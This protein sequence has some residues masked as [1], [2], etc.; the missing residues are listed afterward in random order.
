MKPHYDTIPASK[1]E[2]DGYQVV[3]GPYATRLPHHNEWLQNVLSDMKGA[4]IV[5]VQAVGGVEVWRHGSEMRK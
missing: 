4:N 5:L 1:A 3:C 2:E